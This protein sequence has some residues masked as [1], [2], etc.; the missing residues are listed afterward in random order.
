M[1]TR[2][3]RGVVLAVAITL[4]SAACTVGPAYHRPETPTP[5]AFK[6]A[7]G[8]KAAEPNDQSPKG[9]WWELFG[10]AQLNAL[11]EQLTVRN[12]QL[13]FSMR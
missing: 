3:E 8:W 7:D 13:I 9:K 6:E 12:T 2:V 11:E 4:G 1:T 5:P 10:D